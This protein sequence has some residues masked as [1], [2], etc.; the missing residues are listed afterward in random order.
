MHSLGY[1]AAV[2]AAVVMFSGG[3]ALA[4][5][6]QT[7]HMM[8]ATTMPV[9]GYCECHARGNSEGGTVVSRPPPH[10]K[11]NATAGGCGTNPNATGCH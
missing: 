5:V 11:I 3:A 4:R 10:S 7:D 9:D 8:C 1:A 6:C 2:C